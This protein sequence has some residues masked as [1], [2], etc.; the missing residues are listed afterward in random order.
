MPDQAPQLSCNRASLA[1]H[2]L[3]RSDSGLDL[4]SGALKLVTALKVA[5]EVCRG[6]DYLHKRNIV[7]RDLKA[8][9]LLLD[10]AGGVKIGDF[11]VAR[12]MTTAGVMTA[13]TGTYRSTCAPGSHACLPAQSSR[14]CRC[15]AAT[16]QPVHPARLA[17]VETEMGA[18]N[19]RLMS[20]WM[21]P[22][23]IEHH[24]YREKA[25]V[26]SFAITV[27][28][29]LTARVPYAEMTPLQA[30]ALQAAQPCAVHHQSLPACWPQYQPPYPA[31]LHACSLGLLSCLTIRASGPC[32]PSR[33]RLSPHWTSACVKLLG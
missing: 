3:V 24:P 20:R 12:V 11:G 10:D 2:Q 27:W 26:F 32:L 1:W 4:Q 29:L 14:G 15:Y 5:T 7:H 22:E 30:R 21:A 19:T 28:E 16:S 6:M 25:D 33:L 9:N 13:E 31:G 18:L 17:C 8:A 23:V